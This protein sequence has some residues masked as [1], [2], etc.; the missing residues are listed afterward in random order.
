[1]QCVLE[2]SAD[3]AARLTDGEPPGPCVD[4]GVLGKSDE[5]SAATVNSLPHVVGVGIAV[6]IGGLFD[7]VVTDRRERRLVVVRARST[8]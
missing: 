7:G 5:R 2:Q 8:P 6:G 3:I 1:M 4:A